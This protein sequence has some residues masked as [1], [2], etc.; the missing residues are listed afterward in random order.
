MHVAYT[1]DIA[2]AVTTVMVLACT[3]AILHACTIAMVHACSMTTVHA[4]AT[5][6]ILMGTG[7][8]C[9]MIIGIYV[10]AIFTV[11]IV[12]ACTLAI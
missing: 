3:I 2:L 8:T 1:I 6:A 5:F 7:C 9:T 12:L 11:P 10:Y 4:C